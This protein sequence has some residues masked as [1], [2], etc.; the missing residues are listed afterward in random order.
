MVGRSAKPDPLDLLRWPGVLEEPGRDLDAVSAAALALLERA[1]DTLVATRE[2]EGARLAV[3]LLDR[4]D[5]L[6]ESV[7]RVRGLMPLVMDGVRQRLVDRLAELR[8]ELDPNASSRRSRCWPPGS[9]WTRRWTAWRP[10]SPRS[11][12][13]CGAPSRWAVASTS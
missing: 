2:R 10:T 6:Q 8:A 4:C 13:S 7:A 9:T 11:A 1:L 12:T 5:R 3:L